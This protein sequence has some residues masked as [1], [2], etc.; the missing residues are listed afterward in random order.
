[1]QFAALYVFDIVKIKELEWSFI[2][3][4]FTA[5]S[6]LLGVPLGRLVDIIGRK[7]SI[8]LSYLI[9]T[10]ATALFILSRN[11]VHLLIVYI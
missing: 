5:V 3:A 1:M 6:L 4:I 8:I 10:P 9:F 7:K 11:F 2:I